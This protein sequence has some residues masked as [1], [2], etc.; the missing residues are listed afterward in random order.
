MTPLYIGLP[1]WGRR[2]VN[3]ACSYTIPALRAALK[4]GP[5]GG[6]VT[7]VVHTD[8]PSRF[9]EPL[10]NIERDLRHPPREQS[11]AGQAQA[12]RE[13]LATA[14]PDAVVMLLNADVVV[15]REVFAEAQRL[16]RGRIK[17][18]SALG[19]RSLISRH[20]PPIGADAKTLLAWA[21]KH[22]HPINEDCVWGRG[23][24]AIPTLLFFERGKSVT[25]RC[26]HLHPIF[27]RKDR[28]LDFSTTIDDDLM[29][30]FAADEIH[31]LR[32]Q[33]MAFAELSPSSKRFPSVGPLSVERVVRF[34]GP[35]FLPAHVLAFK[36]SIRI[37][38]S[39]DDEQPDEKPASD[40]IAG[41]AA[42]VPPPPPPPRRAPLER[43]R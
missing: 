38:G 22:R 3:L 27:V 10:W 29:S 25:A 34:G 33:E 32:E 8:A 28:D 12:H 17:V 6:P 37:V 14:S 21:W 16:L 30:R 43:R 31:V 2:Y 19:L 15:S 42:W 20:E 11:H 26:F 40:I 7:V 9:V 39:D 5:W 23:G 18:L 24:T 36:N 35:R 41:L 13:V 4:A 1:A